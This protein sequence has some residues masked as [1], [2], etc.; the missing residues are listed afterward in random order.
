MG[1][2]DPI[3]ILEIKSGRLI[4]LTYTKFIEGRKSPGCKSAFFSYLYGKKAGESAR[5]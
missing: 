4:I 3:Q 2:Y 1:N 5:V